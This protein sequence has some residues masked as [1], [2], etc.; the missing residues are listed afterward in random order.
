MRSFPAALA[1]LLA[2]CSCCSAQPG[3]RR[4]PQ[5]RNTRAPM[6]SA[7]THPDLIFFN[8]V[9]YTGAGFAEDHPEVVQAIAIRAGKVVAIGKNEEIMRLAG[10]GTH[11]RD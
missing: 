1:A 11:L 4:H 7:T 2:V 8:G 9:I 10:P 5:A 3:I 6:R